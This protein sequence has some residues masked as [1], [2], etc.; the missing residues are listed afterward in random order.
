MDTDKRITNVE[1]KIAYLENTV[2]DL[3]EVVTT[4]NNEVQS[5]QRENSRMHSQLLEHREALSQISPAPSLEDE[6][7]PHY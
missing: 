1:E 2:A 6:K 7:P 5:L 4:L 3:N